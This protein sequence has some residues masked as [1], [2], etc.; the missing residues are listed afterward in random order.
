MPST[1]RVSIL[2]DHQTIID[3]YIHRLHNTPGIEVVAT[4]LSGEELESMLAEN[5]TDVLILDVQVPTS[6][7]NP[8]LYPI[9][10]LIPNLLEKYSD[11]AIIVISMHNQPSMIKAIMEMGVSGYILKED[12]ETIQNLGKI[13]LAMNKESV[14]LSQQAYKQLF[15]RTPTKIDLTTRQL[16]ALSLCATYPEATLAKIAQ[17]MGIADSTV[18]NILSDA[19]HRLNVRT[20]STAVVKA[21]QLGLIPPPTAQIDV[22]EDFLDK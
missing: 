17:Q 16:E 21:Q 8:N 4:A 7:E 14:H 12:Y 3:G 5:P 20:K 19:Y 6:K 13:I 15:R 18:R 10:N 1:I 11:L 2:D 22:D 9:L